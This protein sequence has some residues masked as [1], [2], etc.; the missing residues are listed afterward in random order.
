MQIVAREQA[1]G[2]DHDCA[3][4]DRCEHRLPQRDLIAEHQQHAI[5][6]LHA[7]RAQPVRDLV[8]ACGERRK[9]EAVLFARLL[10]DPQSN[11]VVA[12]RQGVEVI[13]R[14]IE[15]AQLRQAEVAAHR[16]IVGPVG[17]QEVARL[18]EIG[19]SAHR[20]SFLSC[21]VRGRSPHILD[22]P[23]DAGVLAHCTAR[24]REAKER[25]AT[26][27]A[28]PLPLPRGHRQSPRITPL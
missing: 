22:A 8:R 21:V 28:R 2:G 1:G 19:C 7:L 23:V 10:D 15:F 12:G 17:E 13:E 11:V 16:S 26:I 5:V 27:M 4:L 25:A 3:E 14:P 18:Q 20:G 6:A 24:W 9:R